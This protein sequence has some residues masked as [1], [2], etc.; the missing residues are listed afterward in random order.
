MDWLN[1]DCEDKE[2]R[3]RELDSFPWQAIVSRRGKL[4]GSLFINMPFGHIEFFRILLILTCIL[5]KC[6]DSVSR[7]DGLHFCLLL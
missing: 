7:I 5:Q 6:K 4:S 1:S 3:W 2:R